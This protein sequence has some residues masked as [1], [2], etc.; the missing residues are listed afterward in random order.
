MSVTAILLPVFVQVAADLRDP[1]LD[2]AARAS[3]DH[4]RREREG[5][6]VALG[7]AHWPTTRAQS[8]TAYAQPVRA[9]GALLCADGVRH[10]SPA[11]RPTS[12]SWR[13]P[14]S[15]SATRVLHAV[16]CHT[17]AATTCRPAFVGLRW[18][19]SPCLIIMWALVV[20][21]AAASRPGLSMTPAA[22]LSAAIEVLADIEARRRPAADA[23][24][25]WGLSHRFAGSKDRAA[26]ASLVYDALRRK[27]SAAWL[28][29][30][31]G[32]PRAV[33]ARHA[34]A[35]ARAGRWSHRGAVLG[36]ALRARAADRRTSAGRWRAA[37]ARR[38]AGPCRGRL[39]RNGSSRPLAAPS[40]TTASPRCRRWPPARR[41]TCGSTRSR[42]TATEAGT[43]LCRISAPSTTP[44]S[45]LGPA[46]RARAR[47]AAA[48]PCRPSRPSIKGWIEIQDEG[49]QL[50]ALLAGAEARRAGGRPLRRRRRQDA[51][52]G[53][54]DGQ[55]RPDLRHRQ[56]QAPPRADPR[57]ADPGRASA[58]SRSARPRA[59][60]RCR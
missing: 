51:G 57:P 30:G 9:A 55:P 23:L 42:S 59:Q 41:S 60:G 25:D 14:G 50:A 35:A 53:R 46:H 3:G 43:M 10:L 17:G 8:A 22:R 5:R 39:S 6:R 36:R 15:S 52:A 26:I 4:G 45:P 32:T 11:R 2:S 33:A 20:R 34:E 16:R 56:R 48:P 1:V 13:W 29:D 24:K 47:T 37:H 58:T 7:R 31:R 44:L 28:I 21:L 54:H 27:A 49:S 18:P 19:A 12:S 38:R 40:A